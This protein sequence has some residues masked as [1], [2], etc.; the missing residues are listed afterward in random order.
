MEA[1]M[2]KMEDDRRRQRTSASHRVSPQ[3]PRKKRLSGSQKLI[4]KLGE[5]E[6]T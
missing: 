2:A 4:A 1:K 5:K 3:L 6:S